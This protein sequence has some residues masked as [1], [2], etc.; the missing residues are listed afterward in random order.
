MYKLKKLLA[1]AKDKRVLIVI[2]LLFLAIA[3]LC[4]GWSINGDNFYKEFVV[5]SLFPEM[6]GVVLELIFVYLI[7]SYIEQDRRQNDIIENER[8][9]RS[10]L[11]FFV[12]DLLRHKPLLEKCALDD[13]DF[14]LLSENPE[15]FKFYDFQYNYNCRVISKIS[16]EIQKNENEALCNHIRKHVAIE[17]HALQS[18]LPVVSCVSKEH[19]KVWQRLLYFMS[20]INHGENTV[21]NTMRA[22]A[23]IKSF[24]L[25][26]NK[27]F[28]VQERK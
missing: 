26:T 3:L 10:Y 1:F 2:M 19:F 16:E 15:D 18:M 17:L 24:D 20:L 21:I 7:F 9:A 8:R 27:R 6:I 13:Q 23:K 14:K 11:R 22:L 5:G 12:F 28:N 4:E 25:N